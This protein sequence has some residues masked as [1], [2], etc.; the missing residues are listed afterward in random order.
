MSQ[1]QN[2]QGKDDPLVGDIETITGNSG[3][4]AGADGSGNFNLTGDNPTGINVV[5]DPITFSGKIF[6]LASSTTQVGT[7]ALATGL[8]T[9]TGT[10]A[11]KAVT[12]AGL[13]TKLGSQT[14]H[15]IPYGNATTGA[16]L[17]LAEAQNGYFP[18]GST[19]SAPV[20]GTITSLD[21][22]LDVT[23]GAGTIDIKIAD[24]AIGTAQTIGA[25]TADVLTVPLG[26]TPGTYQF[27][28]RVKAFE[29]T[30]PA[31]A[32]YN[33]Y[34]TFTTDGISATLVGDQPVFNEDPALAAGDA[35]FIASG[36][37]AIL[38]V[39]GVVGLTID[40]SGETEIT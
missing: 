11:T 19:G 3:G 23:L 26:A 30:T 29:S 14:S 16:I 25:V 32:G 22:S 31:G 4:A 33:I 20:L 12:P 39:L 8:E 38:Q 6:G 9:T 15:G 5:T 2:F 27:E 40:W 35:Y 34:G 24:T 17:W 18:I 28:A 21:G 7:V 10:N 1:L 37:N 13:A 36:N